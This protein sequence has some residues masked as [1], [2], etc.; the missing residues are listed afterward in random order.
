MAYTCNKIDMNT[1]KYLLFLYGYMKP[2]SNAQNPDFLIVILFQ[3]LLLIKKFAF[4][5]LVYNFP[6][7][8]NVL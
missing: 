5:F 3:L 6:L 8:K 2:M 1:L 4:Y 7:Y